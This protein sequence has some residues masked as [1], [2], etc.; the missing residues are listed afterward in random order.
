MNCLAPS[1]LS[2]DYAVLG[3]QL[4]ILDE[5]GA[6]YVHIDIADGQ[7]VPSI[8]M[9]IPVVK[10]IRKCTDR[11]FDVHM[12]VLEPERFIDELS[13]AG[14]DIVTVHAEACRHL[15][16]TINR[17]KENGLLA[18]VALNP[19][20]PLNV[21]E[22]V[23]PK[24]DMALIMTVNPGYGGQKAI[25]YTFR[26]VAELK[27]MIDKSGC[28]VDIEVDGGVT[29]DNVERFLDAGANIIV[30]GSAVFAGEME[31]NVRRFMDILHQA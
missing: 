7:F 21:L 10:T 20:T 30:S 16:N 12:M 29:L 8:T 15:D 4:R 31:E 6:Q 22:Y 23:L 17:I 25:P 11:M 1:I 14:A 18:G 19:E 27:K 2:A 3:E 28:R 5:A 24:I 13:E 9:G 26:K